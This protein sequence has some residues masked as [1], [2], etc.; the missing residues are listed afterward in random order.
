VGWNIDPEFKDP[1]LTKFTDMAKMNF[2]QGYEFSETSK[3]K[4]VFR[5]D[6]E[7]AKYLN[8]GIQY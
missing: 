6:L 5:G 2:F 8:R 3:L 4:K 7:T 1:D